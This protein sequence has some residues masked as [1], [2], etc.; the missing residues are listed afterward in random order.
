MGRTVDLVVTADYK[1]A[2]NVAVHAARCGQR[3]LVVLR[4]GNVQTAR[5]FRRDVRRASNGRGTHLAVISNAEVVCVDGTDRVE[6]IVIRRRR[7]G[8]LC[9]V[10]ASA[11]VS[12][13]ND[14][15]SAA[16]AADAVLAPVLGACPARFD[17]APFQGFSG[18]KQPHARIARR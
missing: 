10:N 8:R 4:S 14:T 13:V 16:G 9:A 2:L 12:F 17:E 3:V 11:F 6:A 7:T 18:T 5:R 1:T 15:K